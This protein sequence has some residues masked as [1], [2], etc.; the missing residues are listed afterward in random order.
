MNQNN[1]GP[2]RVVEINITFHTFTHLNASFYSPWYLF[3]ML[4]NLSDF[5]C[6]VAHLIHQFTCHK[7][8]GKWCRIVQASL[9]APFLSSLTLSLSHFSSSFPHFSSLLFSS[10]SLESNWPFV[11][12]LR[13]K[14]Y[15]ETQQTCKW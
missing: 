15:R 11:T 3:S 14:S 1:S 13:N 2:Y 4:N 10:L 6:R 12:A 8:V 7:S 5:F 9:A